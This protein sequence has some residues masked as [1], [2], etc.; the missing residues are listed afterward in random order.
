[1]KSR[2]MWRWQ[3]IVIAMLVA[4]AGLVTGVLRA[5]DASAADVASFLTLREIDR[6]AR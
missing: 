6:S 5:D 3:T 2:S 1:M 4:T